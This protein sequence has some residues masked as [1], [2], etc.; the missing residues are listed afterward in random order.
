MTPGRFIFADPLKLTPPIVLVFASMVALA[1]LPVQDPDEP[2]VLPV[3]FPV[4]L[5]AYIFLNLIAF[6][7]ISKAL[8]VIGSKWPL[9]S[10]LILFE[11]EPL[12]PVVNVNPSFSI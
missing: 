8:S 11:A 5:S 12:P 10:S 2:E 7:P 9:V 6:E 1:A 4:K 3:K